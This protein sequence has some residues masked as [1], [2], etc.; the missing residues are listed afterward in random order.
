M[1]TVR[2]KMISKGAR[3]ILRSDKVREDLER[4]ATRIARAAGGTQD[5]AVEAQ[6]GANRARAS[7][8]TATQKARRAEATRRALTRAID[9]GR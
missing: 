6:V 2:V 5:F 1:V 8:R 7:V 9:A 4:R 3:A